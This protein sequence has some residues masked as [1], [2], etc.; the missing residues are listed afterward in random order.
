MRKKGF[1]DLLVLQ[2]SSLI[3]FREV[4]REFLYLLPSRRCVT[5]MMCETKVWSGSRF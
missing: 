5:R 3:I 4:L 1:T 2:L